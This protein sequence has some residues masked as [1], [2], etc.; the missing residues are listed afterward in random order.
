MF[1]MTGQLRTEVATEFSGIPLLHL[2]KYSKY[3]KGCVKYNNS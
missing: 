1:A 3:K 2:C